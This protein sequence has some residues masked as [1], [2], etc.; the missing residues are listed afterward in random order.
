VSEITRERIEMLGQSFIPQ[1]SDSRVL[2]QLIYKWKH[3]R[4]QISDALFDSYEQ[5]LNS[6]RAVAPQEVSRDVTRM[7]S[8]NFNEWVN[9]SVSESH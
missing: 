5:L 1:H 4:K 6:G 3:A 7:F 8:G 9:P 2:E